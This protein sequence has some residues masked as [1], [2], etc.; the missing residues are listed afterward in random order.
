[1]TSQHPPILPFFLSSLLPSSSLPCSLAALLHSSFLS[2][3]PPLL[4]CQN[5]AKLIWSRVHLKP[6][7]VSLLSFVCWVLLSQPWHFINFYCL[8]PLSIFLNQIA[9]NS[10]QLNWPQLRPHRISAILLF[11]ACWLPVAFLPAAV[12]DVSEALK[13]PSPTLFP[14]S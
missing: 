3:V 11:I 4:L 10:D 5:Q 14:P 6:V 12:P 7:Q 8:I 1:M 13:S 2:P 9:S